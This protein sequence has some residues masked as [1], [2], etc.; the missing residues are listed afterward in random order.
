ML[1][2]YQK[3][4]YKMMVHKDSGDLQSYI[5]STLQWQ[6]EVYQ[7]NYQQ[8]LL[9]SLFKV[10]GKTTNLL[11]MDKF[12]QI[13]LNDIFLDYIQ[14]TP[15]TN[16]NLSRY[17]DHFP[18]W[19]KSAYKRYNLPEYIL[20]LTALEILLHQSYYANDTIPMDVS[21]FSVLSEEDQ[22]STKFSRT[23]S[24]RL[25]QSSWDFSELVDGNIGNAK[26]HDKSSSFYIIYRNEGVPTWTTCTEDIYNLLEF[27]EHP[28]SLSS[29]SETKRFNSEVNLPTLIQRSWVTC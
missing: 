6:T 12:K 11:N 14:D 17:G 7:T 26:L 23:N 22:V 18:V 16:Q 1:D 9:A 15:S 19:L 28:R 21:A 10:F 5:G 27:L 29:I 13:S 20:D 24:M 4:F 25:F 3:A 2:S 8:A